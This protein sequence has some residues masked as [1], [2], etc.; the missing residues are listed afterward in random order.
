MQFSINVAK[1]KVEF[2]PNF[3]NRSFETLEEHLKPKKT[4]N[5]F[6]LTARALNLYLKQFS[7]S[8]LLKK[9]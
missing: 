2:L 8:K 7:W 3:T 9:L 6:K 4:M 5:P 1:F